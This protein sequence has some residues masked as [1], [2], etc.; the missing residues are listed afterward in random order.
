MLKK[1]FLGALL[2]YIS[3]TILLTGYHFFFGGWTYL[4]DG[5]AE[6]Y[7]YNTVIFSAGGYLLLTLVF[8]IVCPLVYLLFYRIVRSVMKVKITVNNKIIYLVASYV[9][10]IILVTDLFT[11]SS[12]TGPNMPMTITHLIINWIILLGMPFLLNFIYIYTKNNEK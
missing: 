10:T 9:V 3:A 2:G 5:V 6:K 4:L 7:S 8:L 12:P 1:T 11:G